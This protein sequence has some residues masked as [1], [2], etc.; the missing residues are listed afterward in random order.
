MTSSE[1]KERLIAEK[2]IRDRERIAAEESIKRIHAKINE[3]TDE[4]RTNLHS[5]GFD[6]AFI[7]NIDL[8]RLATDKEYLGSIHQQFDQICHSL[9]KT[10][11]EEVSK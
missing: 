8:E 11:E 3:I 6:T 9:L 2:A 7:D 4:D 5:L 10:L 1:I